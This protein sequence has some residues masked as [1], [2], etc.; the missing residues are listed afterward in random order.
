MPTINLTRDTGEALR[1][2]APREMSSM[3][4][5]RDRFVGMVGEQLGQCC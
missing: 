1:F 3:A 5:L 4:A 2:E